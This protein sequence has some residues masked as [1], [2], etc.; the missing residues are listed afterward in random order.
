MESSWY[1]FDQI[2]MTLSLND[3]KPYRSILKQESIPVGCEPPACWPYPVVSYVS[4]GVCPTTPDADTPGCR[5]PPPGYRPPWMQNPRCRLLL[6]MWPAMHVG[7]PTF[8]PVNRMTDKCKNITLQQTSFADGNK[9]LLLRNE[10]NFDIKLIFSFD[11][12]N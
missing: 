2:Q 4:G 8:P 11:G 5:P 10:G 7:K 12:F 6:T 9:T 1:E 3:A